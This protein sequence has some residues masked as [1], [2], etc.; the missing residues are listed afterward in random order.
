MRIA[1][2][3]NLIMLLLRTEKISAPALA[4]RFEVS[5][6]TIYRDVETLSMAGIPIYG[7]RGRNG[8]IGLMANYKIDKKLLTADD[9]RNLR[10]ALNGVHTLIANPKMNATMQKLDAF[11]A[12]DHADEH[13]LIDYANW[14]GTQELK[15]LAEQI[16][17]TIEQHVYLEFKY[18]DRNGNQTSRRVEPYRLVYKSERWYL[19]AYSVE[20][21][22]FRMFRLSRIHEIAVINKPFEPRAVPT[23]DFNFNDRLRPEMTAVTVQVNNIARGP[24]VERFG[25]QVI[26]SQTATTFN[27][28]VE[29]PLS[30]N[31]YLFILSMG[32]QIKI[33]S[34]GPFYQGFQQYLKQVMAQ[35][36]TQL[37]TNI[38]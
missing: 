22:D 8:G 10:L 35:Y 6:R 15:Q 9:I 25:N 1:R 23:L 28:T 4:T 16:D 32:Q 7:L 36:C 26:E 38:E 21:A 13:L 5:V 34:D 20:R 14:P 27:A 30:E 31:A 37:D 2:L 24:F 18:S 11:Y 29:L 12:E 33:I 17:Q 19:Q 3:I